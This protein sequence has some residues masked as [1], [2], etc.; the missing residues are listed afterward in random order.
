[1]S[2]PR[3]G[4]ADAAPLR[5]APLT[6]VCRFLGVHEKRNPIPGGGSGSS[7]PSPVPLGV[8]RG[9]W[10]LFFRF[11]G[12]GFAHWFGRGGG[13]WLPRLRL[14]VAARGRSVARAGRAARLAVVG[15]CRRGR[16]RARSGVR[17]RGRSGRVGFGAGRPG[18]PL[19]ARA[20]AAGLAARAGGVVGGAGRLSGGGSGFLAPPL[21]Y[22][23][24]QSV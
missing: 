23:R 17:R 15:R 4:C 14:G 8:C 24:Q 18:S 22:V 3:Q 10:S 1:M 21:F 9:S 2:G 16:R 7:G 5:Y 6:L 20:R 11:V 19:R 12:S 13:R